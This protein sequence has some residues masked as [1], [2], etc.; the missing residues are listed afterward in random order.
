MTVSKGG[1]FTNIYIGN[2]MKRGDSSLNPTEP[3][4]VCS[5]PSE[6]AE[7]PEPTPLTEPVAEAKNEEEAQASGQE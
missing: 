4:E 6:P 3:P 2:A 1:K 5:D 7:L